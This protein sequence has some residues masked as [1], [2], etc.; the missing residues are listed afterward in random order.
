MHLLKWKYQPEK[1]SGSWRAT[2]REHRRRILKAFKNSPSLQRYFED[3]FEESY[4]ESRKQAADETELD[5]KIFPQ[6]CPF[7]PK[8]ILD[9]EY[10]PNEK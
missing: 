5:L 7:K 2:I 8:E 4:E 9:S 10:L 3:I 1:Q 6:S